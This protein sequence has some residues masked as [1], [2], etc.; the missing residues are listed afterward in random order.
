MDGFNASFEIIFGNPF[1][2]LPAE[3]PGNIFRLAGKKNGHIPVKGTTDRF[4]R[5]GSNKVVLGDDR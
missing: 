4:N 3:S 1:V 5:H 2:Y